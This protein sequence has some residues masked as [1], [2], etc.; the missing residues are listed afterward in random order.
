M[1]TGVQ[2]AAGITRIKPSVE[3]S[4]SHIGGKGLPDGNR[5]TAQQSLKKQLEPND[6]LLTKAFSDRNGIPSREISQR[7][8]VADTLTALPNREPV[9]GTAHFRHDS[10]ALMG[11][12]K[13]MIKELLP[14]LQEA[15]KRGDQIVLDGHTSAVGDSKYNRELSR[16]RAEAIKE[17]LVSQGIPAEKIAIQC[18]G[19]E[20]LKTKHE[21]TAQDQAENR[22]VEIGVVRTATRAASATEVPTASA[23]KPTVAAPASTPQFVPSHPKDAP[24]FNQ[25]KLG[26]HLL[27]MRDD[28][29][30][31]SVNTVVG[32]GFT[33][34]PLGELGSLLKQQ[35]SPL[36][37]VEGGFSTQGNTLRIAGGMQNLGSKA[38]P[39]PAANAPAAGNSGFFQQRAEGMLPERPGALRFRQE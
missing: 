38:E 29:K 14:N 27:E 26:G 30:G 11:Q 31:L 4:H 25:P 28:G 10:S 8:H 35:P 21:K 9:G 19:E 18:H 37:S 22:R 13:S 3:A 17:Y 1:E 12:T 20:K 39:A 24:L 6:T 5:G 16:R 15:V 2:A 7:G 23:A 34:R 33:S 36:V 32:S